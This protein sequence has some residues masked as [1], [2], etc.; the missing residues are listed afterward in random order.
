MRILFGALVIAAA[1][2]ADTI[3]PGQS[4]GS[5]TG[6]SG[7]AGTGGSSS[8]ELSPGGGGGH[9]GSRVG[10][11]GPARW[12]T[13]CVA[14]MEGARDRLQRRQSAVL[15]V[16]AS[17][18]AETVTLESRCLD[19]GRPHVECDSYWAMVSVY[20]ARHEAPVEWSNH[21]NG[22]QT[23]A[24]DLRRRG[25]HLEGWVEVT[26]TRGQS[27]IPVLQRAVDACLALGEVGDG[28]W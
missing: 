25:T 22:S 2:H 28:D 16:H 21:K 23:S 13:P 15:S 19:D 26:G 18:D 12:L 24:W 14:R 1:A 17:S 6:A 27:A 9:Q 11:R 5:P 4:T 3:L 20:D 10:M 8:G 7:R